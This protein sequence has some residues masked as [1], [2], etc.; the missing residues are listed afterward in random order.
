MFLDESTVTTM[1]TPDQS[2]IRTGVSE[3]FAVESVNRWH[4]NSK[5]TSKLALFVINPN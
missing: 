5:S 2:E 3:P 1:S 4:Y